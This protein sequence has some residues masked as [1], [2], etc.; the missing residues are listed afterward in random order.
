MTQLPPP[1]DAYFAAA[2]R[3]DRAAMADLFAETAAVRDE[4]ETHVD[5]SAIRGW[6]DRVGAS[7]DPRYVIQGVES[8]AEASVVTVEVSGTFPGSPI[9][10]RQR[11]VTD[12]ERITSLAT[13]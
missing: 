7:Y 10:L 9:V 3:G 12:G 13:L 2:N 8:A 4:G 11:F 6:L 5:P 1:L